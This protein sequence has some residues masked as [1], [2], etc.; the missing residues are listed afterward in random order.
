MDQPDTFDVII[1]GGGPAGLSA[2]LWCDEL[3]L[4][5]LVLEK[6]TET[7]G[8][9][10]WT[11]N[12]IENHLGTEAADGRELRDI[13]S[14]Q[15]A[16]REFTLRLGAEPK[17]IDLRRRTVRL[18]DD[19]VHTGRAVIVATGVRRRTLGI[20]GEERFAG[21]GLLT[22]GKRDRELVSGR[23]VLVV[24]GGDAALE[25]SLILAETAERVFVAHRRR[26][27]RAREEFLRPA[28]GSDRIEFLT[29][30]VLRKI[31]GEERIERVEL[32]NTDEQRTYELKVDAVILRIG[33]RPNTD[34]FEGQLELDEQG[35][36]RVDS[37]GRTN[38]PGV[39]AVGDAA[40]PLSPTVSTAVGS[41]AT[42][43]K[44]LHAE[45]C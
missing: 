12:R 41:G 21:R 37:V 5:A 3:K 27:F 19:A 20:E 22:S 39:Y 35:Y 25:N 40:N 42:A 9:L 8:Q 11:Y 7:G 38:L 24:G 16:E 44:A 30:T 18:A 14:R 17:E 29:D 28:L 32:E 1:I 23:R 13:F 10:L 33:V 34:L 26:E 36:I 45:L 15:T 2:A 31:A 4:S 43:V 6:E